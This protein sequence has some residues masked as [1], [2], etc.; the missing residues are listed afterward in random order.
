MLQPLADNPN[1]PTFNQTVFSVEV[2]PGTAQ[3][4]LLLALT[5]HYNGAGNGD[6]VDCTCADI[7]YAIESGNERLLFAIDSRTGEMSTSKVLFPHAG[8]EF[9]YVVYN[10]NNANNNVDNRARVCGRVECMCVIYVYCASKFE[11][12]KCPLVD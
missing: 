8:Q 4:E 6:T 12:S 7:R 2:S 11:T 10:N 1:V 3:G 5:A 9:E